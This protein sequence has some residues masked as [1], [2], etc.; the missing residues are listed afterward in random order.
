MMKAAQ[1]SLGM[2][3]MAK[4]LL[5]DCKIKIVVDASAALGVAQ[6]QGLGNIRQL[7]TG[8]LWIHEQELKRATQMNKV[9]GTDNCS[10]IP[11]NNVWREVLGR[12]A[13]EMPM[14]YRDGRA[15]KA[16]QLHLL[17]RKIRQAKA[18]IENIW[19]SKPTAVR[20][21]PFDADDLND[22][23]SD[24][25]CTLHKVKLK[26]G[27]ALKISIEDRERQFCRHAGM[28]SKCLNNGHISID[29]PSDGTF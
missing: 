4:E 3:A 26:D 25:V 12:H 5:M 11:A 15:E 16:V 14:E 18:V 29:H 23:L 13:A 28:M 10:D 20:N 27:G 22:H 7:Q 21:E 1:E 24:A 6:I 2:A 17:Q 8:S 19:R 9:K